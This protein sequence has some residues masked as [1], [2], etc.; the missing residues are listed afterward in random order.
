MIFHSFFVVCCSCL[1]VAFSLY[2]D[3]DLS[4]TVNSLQKSSKKTTV[5]AL[6]LRKSSIFDQDPQPDFEK[7]ALIILAASHQQIQA[8]NQICTL[9][10]P[11]FDQ[12]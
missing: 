8:K 9:D 5:K 6:R 10:S 11:I 2:H 1:F 3:L 4:L 7:K 12:D